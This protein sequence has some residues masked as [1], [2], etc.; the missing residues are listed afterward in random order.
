[1]SPHALLC[2]TI[3]WRMTLPGRQGPCEPSS[4]ELILSRVQVWQPWW[5]ELVFLQ[6]AILQTAF[7]SD[8]LSSYRPGVPCAHVLGQLSWR[9]CIALQVVLG[10]D[11]MY[12]CWVMHPYLGDHR[13]GISQFI[14]MTE[15]FLGNEGYGYF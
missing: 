9:G 4:R 6:I 2:D 8:S 3:P 7:Q 5:Q 15:L 12:R 1:M 13:A 10:E 14:S 11:R